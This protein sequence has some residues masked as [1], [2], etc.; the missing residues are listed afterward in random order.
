M[1]DNGTY[2]MC[3][4]CHREYRAANRHKMEAWRTANRDRILAYN[5]MYEPRMLELVKARQST[6]KSRTVPFT[7]EQLTARLSYFGNR[8]WICSGEAE[9]L[10]HVKPI[11]SGGWHMLA[12][13]RPACARCNRRKSSLW[14]ISEADLQRI[15][16]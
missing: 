11:K 6:I 14:P 12:N 15:R 2:Y 9:H 16:Q 4:V 8:C 1:K 7:V 13:L 10:D 3:K 5:R